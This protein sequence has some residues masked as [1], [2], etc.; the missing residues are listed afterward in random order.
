MAMSDSFV[1]SEA[2]ESAVSPALAAG[3]E[4]KQTKNASL[5]PSHLSAVFTA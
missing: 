3:A 1:V 5:V 4:R 2:V